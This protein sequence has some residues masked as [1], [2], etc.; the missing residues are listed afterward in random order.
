M[1]SRLFLP[2]IA[3]PTASGKTSLAID[4]AIRHGGEVVSADSMQ[5]YSGVQIGT[6][7][8]TEQEM[9]GIPHHLQGF[10]P[11]SERYSVACYVEDA[12]RVIKEIDARG[13]LPILCGGTGLYIDALIDN[14]SFQGGGG[15]PEFRQQLRRR[16]EREGGESL[17]EELRRVDESTAAKLHP[18]NL[19]RIIRALELVNTTGMTMSEQ[20][21][22]SR[23]QPSPYDA[24]VIVLDCRDRAFLYDRINRRV[25]AMME[26]GLLEEAGTAL[27]Y[28][29]N[30]ESSAPTAM[31]AIGYKELAP[32]FE[33]VLPL[34]QAVDNLKQATRRY[35]KR[36][37][38]WFRRRKDAHF[39][40]ID[41]YS[42]AAC[43]TKKASEIL[44]GYAHGHIC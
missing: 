43:L 33:G 19:G 36:Q 20:V 26:A 3:G 31:Q 2:V 44:G 32:Y 1:D 42:D 21:R 17:L 35:A 30:T 18:N 10:L 4:L 29:S 6:A 12:R 15:D 25:D 38:S 16:A 11:L 5:I 23:T 40:Y 37:L 28:N 14:L 24:C 7:R 9:K 13:K 22:L 27:A 39:L 34:Q 41:E 8:P